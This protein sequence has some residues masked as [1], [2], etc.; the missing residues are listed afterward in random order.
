MDS[1]K[2]A[3]FDIVETTYKLVDDQ[4]IKAY[5]FTPKNIHAGKHPVLVKFHGGFLITGSSLYAEWFPQ[6]ALDYAHLHSAII[7]TPDYRLLPESSG[8]DILSDLSSFWTWLRSDLQPFLTTAVPGVEADLERV[9]TYGESAGGYL[10]IQSALLCQ[11]QPKGFIGAVIAT[12]PCIDLESRFYAEA[13]EKSVFGAP[14]LPPSILQD[15]IASMKKGQIVTAVDP[16]GR[17]Q[18]ALST[19]QQG[20]FPEF[21]GQDDALYPF[22]LVNKMGDVAGDAVPFMLILHGRD[23]TAVPVEGSHKFANKVNEKFGDGKVVLHTEPGEHGFDGAATLE[24][25]WLSEGLKK[26]TREWL[27]VSEL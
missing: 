17:M 2:Y 12:Y 27:G 20:R 5:L 23:D 15:H 9:A 21:L 14:M 22:R 3:K 4:P 10:A 16:P 11:Q 7:V 24:T 13:Y 1:P 19:V 8:L 26:V 6:W 25:G 18:L